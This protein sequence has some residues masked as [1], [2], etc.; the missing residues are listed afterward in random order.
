VGNGIGLTIIDSLDTMFIMNL[1]SE[2]NRAVDYLKKNLDFNQNKGIS[3]FE[4]TIRV[5]GF[6]YFYYFK[7]K[8][9]VF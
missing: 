7:Y 6:F 9:E 2:F 1:T 3:F 4:T 8:K 5:L